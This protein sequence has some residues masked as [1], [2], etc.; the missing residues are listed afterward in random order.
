MLG[1]DGADVFS[2]E[3]GKVVVVG[4][5]G[6]KEVVVRKVMAGWVV[7]C[8]MVQSSTIVVRKRCKNPNNREGVRV[9]GG[10]TDERVMS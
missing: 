2:L 10:G 8:V 5:E 7:G 4:L 9:G 3:D 6:K 1:A